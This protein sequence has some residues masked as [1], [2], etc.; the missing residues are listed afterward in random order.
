MTENGQLTKRFD[1]LD[2]WRGLAALSVALL[3]YPAWRGWEG[4]ENRDVWAVAVPFFFML[5]GF[6]LSHSL[7]SRETS[8]FRAYFVR[9]VARLY[10]L[11]I[12]TAFAM[13]LMGVLASVLLATAFWLSSGAFE[14][15][16]DGSRYSMQSL[17]DQLLMLQYIGLSATAWNPPA[18]S[19]S[20]EFWCALLMFPL[21][22][23][24]KSP[25][26][27]LVSIIVVLV[28]FV[29]YY[30]DGGFLKRPGADLFGIAYLNAA[31]FLGLGC[32]A[33]GSLAYDLYRW[34]A[35]AK[36]KTLLRFLE[37]SVAVASVA[38]FVV[39]PIAGN[40]WGLVPLAI[41]IF[42]FPYESGP[43]SQI[44]RI[45]PLVHLG[46]ISYSVYLLHFPMLA[47]IDVGNVVLEN[48]AP[49]VFRLYRGLWADKLLYVV[50]L[51]LASH[52]SFQHFEKPAAKYVN[53]VL[54]RLP[55]KA[56]SV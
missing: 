32:F 52:L 45:A 30:L 42:V 3:H 17:A 36:R 43:I 19:L 38:M 12:A 14:V 20:V 16:F 25:G 54:A 55:G 6:V 15:H 51:L 49:E 33:V 11:H 24:V 13:P 26:K 18:W 39:Y 35:L 34:G 48:A 46:H 27:T 9:R 10:P 23:A 1:V 40:E 56:V 5:S 41:A 7:H 8:T 22:A 37:V 21:L 47:M 50:A 53:R 31:P 28:C 4:A 44:L 2:S 29:P